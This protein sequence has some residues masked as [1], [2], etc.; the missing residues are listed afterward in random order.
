MSKLEQQKKEFLVMKLITTWEESVSSMIKFP[1]APPLPWCSLTSQQYLPIE[2][3]AINQ[4][5]RPLK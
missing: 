5:W 3:F 2:G 4:I 1:C